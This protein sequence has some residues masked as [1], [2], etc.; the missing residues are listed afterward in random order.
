MTLLLKTNKINDVITIFVILNGNKIF[1]TQYQISKVFD[2]IYL[3]DSIYLGNELDLIISNI[4]N[5]VISNFNLYIGDIYITYRDK[6]LVIS[7]K[8]S[9]FLLEIPINNENY[10]N[11]I[12]EL[13]NIRT[14]LI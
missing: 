13:E 10:N 8:K 12:Q 1:T 4:E 7:N 6:K 11:I 2:I 5:T 3:N 14:Y 9:T